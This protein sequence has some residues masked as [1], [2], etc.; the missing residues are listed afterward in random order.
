MHKLN[1]APGDLAIVI[2]AKIPDNIGHIVEVLGPFASHQHRLTETGQ[3]WKVKTVS[4]R[5]SLHY[6]FADGQRFTCSEG[7]VPDHV[8]RPVSGLPET[9]EDD[10]E[11]WICDCEPIIERERVS[12]VD[13][14]VYV[15]LIA[16]MRCLVAGKLGDEVDVAAELL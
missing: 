5:R 6:R 12:V 10:E 8:L 7:P 16:A 2:D 13:T 9:T 3:V 15:P 1:C 14:G 11:V 4:G